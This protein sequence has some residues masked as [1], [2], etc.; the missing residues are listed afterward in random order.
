MRIQEENMVIQNLSEKRQHRT[1]THT[2]VLQMGTGLLL[3]QS[4]IIK[5]KVN[6]YPRIRKEVVRK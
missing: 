6:I 1:H 5:K 4:I 3:L 2:L